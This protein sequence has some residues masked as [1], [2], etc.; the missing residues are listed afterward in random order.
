MRR[1]DFNRV[2]GRGLMAVF[3]LP[4]RANDTVAGPVLWDYT[5]DRVDR[6][7]GGIVSGVADESRTQLDQWSISGWCCY[8]QDLRSHVKKA[9][10]Q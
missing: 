10:G 1:D 3:A 6:N 2:V 4:G 9:D 8:G 5:R 7:A